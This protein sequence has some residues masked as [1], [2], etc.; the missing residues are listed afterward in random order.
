[1]LTSFG[2]LFNSSLF[3]QLLISDFLMFFSLS[4]VI[5]EKDLSWPPAPE[6]SI[7]ARFPEGSINPNIAGMYWLPKHNVDVVKPHSFWWVLVNEQKERSKHY[8]KVHSVVI[9]LFWWNKKKI[10]LLSLKCSI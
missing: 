9:L 8:I 10:E 1:M 4:L 6:N 5:V 7:I 3:W 2:G